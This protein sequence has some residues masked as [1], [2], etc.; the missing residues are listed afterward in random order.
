MTQYAGNFAIAATAVTF[1]FPA[2][3]YFVI[4]PAVLLTVEGAP[5]DVAVVRVKSTVTGVGSVTTG[6]ALTFAAGAVGKR[7]SLLVTGE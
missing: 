2:G 3:T 7:F 1:A 6:L 5:T 4:D